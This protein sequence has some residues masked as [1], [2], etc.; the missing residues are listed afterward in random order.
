M[1]V[2]AWVLRNGDDG[3][4]CAIECIPAVMDTAKMREVTASCAGKG[5]TSVALRR[6]TCDGCGLNI[7]DKTAS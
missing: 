3:A 2:K 5:L 6:L 7:A 4:W 1:R